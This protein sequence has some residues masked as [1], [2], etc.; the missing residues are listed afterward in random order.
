VPQRGL[1]ECENCGLIFTAEQSGVVDCRAC[2]RPV[3]KKAKSCP[4]CGEPR[5]TEKENTSATHFLI[6]SVV[7]AV[8][9]MTSVL[10]CQGPSGDKPSTSSTPSLSNKVGQTITVRGRCFGATSPES[11][12]KAFEIVQ[13]RDYSAISRMKASGEFVD[14]PDGTRITVIDI[15]FMKAKVR[16]EGASSY[17]WTF[18]KW[19]E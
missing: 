14:I 16:I 7:V 17:I 12:D 18:N 8:F 5:E 3:S 4:L 2:G 6:A 9:A 13:N 10:F 1:K 15:T 19:I 11:L